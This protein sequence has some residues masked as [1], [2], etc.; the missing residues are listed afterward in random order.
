MY[1]QLKDKSIVEV[2]Y[3]DNVDGENL[4]RDINN[5]TLYAEPDIIK[6]ILDGSEIIKFLKEAVSIASNR[7][8][9]S[10]TT[11]VCQQINEYID[12]IKLN[13]DWAGCQGTC[14]FEESFNKSN[15]G[16]ENMKFL[17]K[18]KQEDVRMS[19]DAIMCTIL[20]HINDVEIV[21]LCHDYLS[22]IVKATHSSKEYINWLQKQVD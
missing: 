16:I 9:T 21:G 14:D 18:K 1:A 4:Y 11:E 22:R 2:K 7:R 20:I 17:L 6:I 3:Y 12:N 8:P 13:S 15:G 5:S 19:V 10:F